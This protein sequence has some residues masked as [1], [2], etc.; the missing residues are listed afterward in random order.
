M[1]KSTVTEEAEYKLPK[2]TPLPAVLNS[3]EEKVI[4]YVK[5]GQ[6]KT[7]TKWVW[8]F[9]VADG[10]YQGLRA[11][12]DTEDR[13]TTRADNKVRQ[14]AEALLGAEFEIGQDFDTDDVL[15]LPC[16]IVCDHQEYEKKDGSG[17]SYLCPVVQVWPIGTSS[18]T[19]P[20]F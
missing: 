7:F 10:Q 14:F 5:D 13:L 6:K 20:P 12:A 9:E 1:P 19:E 3:V 2:E 4:P 8:E 17:V 15:G 18:D 16:E 11:W